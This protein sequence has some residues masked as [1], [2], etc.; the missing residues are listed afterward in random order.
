MYN[1]I[2]VEDKKI[3]R[4]GLS[5]LIDWESI[6]AKVT[7]VFENGNSAIEYLKTNS[8]NIVLT[9]IEM[10]QGTGIDLSEVIHKNYPGIKII[11]IT[12]FE[13][14]KYAQKAV[15]LGVFAYVLKPIDQ[16]EVLERVK[17][18]IDA[19]GKE[20]DAAKQQTT[21]NLQEFLDGSNSNLPILQQILQIPEKKT[22]YVAISIKS[23]DHTHI[24]SVSCRAAF[25]KCLNHVYTIRLN[26]FLTCIVLLEHHEV[27]T[28]DLLNKVYISLYR[29]CRF[30]VG[31]EVYNLE[32]LPYSLKTSYQAF[33]SSFLANTRGVVRYEELKLLN[34]LEGKPK[35][36]TYLEYNY[37]KGL[38]FQD[39]KEEYEDYVSNVFQTYQFNQVEQKFILNSCMEAMRY[40]C[41]IANEYLIYKSIITLDCSGMMDAVNLSDVKNSFLQQIVVIH[42]QINLKK[43]EK[44]RP[45]VKL[46]LEYS[47][48]NIKDTTL[49]LKMIANHFKI[50]YAYLSKAFKEDFDKSYTEYMNM[51]RIEMAKK[52]LLN[53]DERVYEI[54]EQIG[55]EPK[56]FHFLFKKFEGITPKEFRAINHVKSE[57]GDHP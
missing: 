3:T 20:E 25:A 34:P 54:C 41:H 28:P 24:S 11:M 48:E 43:N 35:M 37:L 27:L 30:C 4:E 7:G 53:S 42:D 52:R 46:A 6:G 40:L 56:N 26:G 31:E 18:A 23:K 50:S 44:I 36:D 32:E 1:I 2:I 14:F 57:Q 38:I 5:R 9:D 17:A 8:V 33:N 39:K 15:E 55:L 29:N 47:V 16:T 49:N 19:M 10:D 22:K 51:Y 12:A 45:I 21:K 13:N